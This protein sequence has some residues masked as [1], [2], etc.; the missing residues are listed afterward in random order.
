M[1]DAS[2]I[3]LPHPEQAECAPTVAAASQPVSWIWLD[4]LDLGSRF[5]SKLRTLRGKRSLGAC[6]VLRRLGGQ[7]PRG[8]RRSVCLKG[9]SASFACASAQ[10]ARVEL[11]VERGVQR[12][13]SATGGDF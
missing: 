10:C 12:D 2:D 9:V 5:G 13:T 8:A 1:A 6:L 7:P 11:S 3:V 4:P